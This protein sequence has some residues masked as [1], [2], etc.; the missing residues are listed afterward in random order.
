[1]DH[2]PDPADT[3]VAYPDVVANAEDALPTV[4]KVP[5][6][7]SYEIIRLFSE[8]LYQSPQKAVEE[9]VS[10]SYDAN[11]AS[12]H[13]LLPEAGDRLDLD[14]TR[15]DE[16]DATTL[17]GSAEIDETVAEANDLP[18]LWVIDDGDGLDIEGFA[19][20]WR[21][22]YSTKASVSE[23]E[24][25]PIGQFGI[26]KLAAYVLAWRLTHISK[27][28]G[29]IRMT[30]MNFRRLDGVHQYSSEKPI[31]LDIKELSLDRA[32]ELMADVEHRDPDAWNFLFGPDAASTWTAARLSDFKDL[33]DKL[34]YGRLDWVLRTGLP[35]HSEFQIWLNGKKLTS[36][37]A[38]RER[39][40]EFV[41][42]SEDDD[43]AASLGLAK[44]ASDPAVYIPGI[45]GAIRGRVE[46]FKRRLTEGKSDQYGRSNGFFIRVRGRVVNLEDELFGL[47]VLNHST[48]ARFSM[49]VEAD[50]LREHLLSS[51]EGVRE[52]DAVDALKEYLL[53]VFNK[54]RKVY[55]KYSDLEQHGV[56]I[57]QL[58]KSTP[59]A[60][61][62]EPI[63]EAVRSTLRTNE[64]SYYFAAPTSESL[65]SPEDW[66]GN[67]ADDIET[68][69]F[70]DI[71]FEGTG[72]YDRIVRY[73]PSTR[74]LVINTD[75][76]F[77]EKLT[78]GSRGNAPAALFGSSEFIIDAL[79]HDYGIPRP[80]VVNFLADRDRVLRIVAG[81]EPSTAKE[82][83]RLLT[84]ALTHE[85]ALERAVGSAFRVLGFEYERR[86]GNAGGADGVLYARLGRGSGQVED[87]KVVY[88]AKQTNQP[89]VAA[90][91]IDFGSLE[92]FRAS[93]SANF[94]F[95]V[96]K[97]FDAQQDA[98]SKLNQKFQNAANP[99][100]PLS[101]LLVEQLQRLVELHYRY[102]LP[103]PM[104]RE[105]FSVP[106]S[107]PDVDSWLDETEE[108]L[109]SEARRVPLL[110]LLE[111]LEQLKGDSLQVPSVKVARYVNKE[112]GAHSPEA[113][114]AILRAVEQI[115]GRRWIEV[116]E[117]ND[118]V[119]LHSTSAQIVAEVERNWRD[120]F[121]EGVDAMTHPE[122]KG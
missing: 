30:S 53:G 114:S 24:R 88:D 47:D 65:D 99:D 103:L 37:K 61:L 89:S 81:D 76:P 22:A 70:S 87:Y 97:K 13:V 100:A 44:D 85:T 3:P 16:A 104:V 57:Q 10:N 73:H 39:I 60:F 26:G 33:Y 111:T 35:L 113:L 119:R 78:A 42:G 38:D 80:T 63:I 4:K 107:V 8:G 75:H 27:V 48:W 94:G 108:K 18:P 121:G 77:V 79:L 43:V 91:K 120:L 68:E 50:G 19:R 17:S 72:E 116:N 36:S 25:L 64:E 40:F 9:L 45:D 122:I 59:S 112:L 96:A 67:Y 20:L 51:R 84:S 66:L 5:V 117:Q 93:E 1:M 12:V 115:I 21:V 82:A 56:D 34:R 110:T 52:N 71:I 15:S 62:T 90:D 95:F 32:K 98:T 74:K 92:A 109:K 2:E 11:A 23:G 106:R 41:V 101:L 55:T 86:G 49:E 102:G 58:L 31:D 6:H 69:V 105:L 14:A 46:L 54:C 118:E 29:S 28:D 83:L 7:I